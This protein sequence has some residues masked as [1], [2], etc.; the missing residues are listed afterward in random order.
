VSTQEPRERHDVADAFGMLD[1]ALLIVPL[2]AVL[3]MVLQSAAPWR[4]RHDLP[5]MMYQAFIAHEFGWLPYRDWFDMNMPGSYATYLAFEHFFGHG[6]V[7][8]RRVDTVWTLGMMAVAVGILRRF[9]WQGAW[10][11]G[12]IFALRYLSYGPGMTLQREILALL[13]L[14]LATWAAMSR[15][16]LRARGFASGFFLALACTYKPHMMVALVPIAAYLAV[17]AGKR[18]ERGE[19][20]RAV[21]RVALP[22]AAGVLLPVLVVLAWLSWHGLLA[23]FRHTAAYLKYYGGMTGAHYTI[24]GV[25]RLGYIGGKLLVSKGHTALLFTGVLGVLVAF[26]N[27]A[28]SASLRR[29]AALLGGILLAF[30][31]YPGLSGQFWS[32][33]FLPM[34]YFAALGSAVGLVGLPRGVPL[35]RWIVPRAALLLLVLRLVGAQDDFRSFTRFERWKPASGRADDIARFLKENL[36]PGETVQP[37]DWV[38]TGVVH[39]MLLAEAKPATRFLYGFHFYHHV[40]TDYIQGLREQLIDELVAGR[41]AYIIDGKA[42]WPLVH[43]HD[44]TT[45]FEELSELLSRDYVRAHRGRRWTA[46]ERRD[47]WEA[48]QPPRPLR[49]RSQRGPAPRD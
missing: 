7:A 4:Y 20:L 29:K 27:E 15:L 23:D 5:M 40:S 25:P 36:E 39:G 44:T 42:V 18:V 6:D 22:T 48:R 21:L 47:R 26:T 46:Y 10:L 49:R 35:A 12:P 34:M 31:L 43:G 9:T 13:P 32:Y 45:E 14:G 16:P 28:F 2:A 3:L 17:E 33:H 41:P 19:R 1:Y 8:M 30:A 38:S 24:S 11:A 37:L